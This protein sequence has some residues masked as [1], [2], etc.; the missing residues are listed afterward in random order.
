MTEPQ[1]ITCVGCEKLRRKGISG[2]CPM[3]ARR[4][5]PRRD[6]DRPDCPFCG[7]PYANGYMTSIGFS[8]EYTCETTAYASA[9]HIRRKPCRQREKKQQPRW[10]QRWRRA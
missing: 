7:A 6:P 8:G 4:R 9:G 2:E 10:W 3:C 1:A 5:M